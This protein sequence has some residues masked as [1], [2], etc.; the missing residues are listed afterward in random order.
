MDALHR[1]W[2]RQPFVPP[3]DWA[4]LA[5]PSQWRGVRVAHYQTGPSELEYCLTSQ[6]CMTLNK[7][8]GMKA[9][10]KDSSGGWKTLLSHPGS[11][12]FTPFKFAGAAR[13]QGSCEAIN[14]YFD[15]GWLDG[16][17]Q[18]YAPGAPSISEPKYGIVDRVV[19]RL[20][21]DVY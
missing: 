11:I 15:V 2:A 14:I 18:D 20:I 16:M 21:D 4:Q 6:I 13:W 19:S 10:C 17:D 3:A 5:R 12:S 1:N 9:E 8:A 7:T